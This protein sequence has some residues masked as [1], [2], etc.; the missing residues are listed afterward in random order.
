MQKLTLLFIYGQDE[1]RRLRYRVT[2]DMPVGVM[3]EAT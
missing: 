3:I 1:E 2:D